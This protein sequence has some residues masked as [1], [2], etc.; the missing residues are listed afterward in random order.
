[1]QQKRH[2]KPI[3]WISIEI[4]QKR[5]NMRYLLFEHHL[6]GVFEHLLEANLNYVLSIDVEF[7]Q[8]I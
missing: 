2:H 8:N 6:S 1:M 3:A 7:K 5:E 4:D